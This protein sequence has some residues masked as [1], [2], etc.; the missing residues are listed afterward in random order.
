MPLPGRAVN[1]HEREPEHAHGSEE[2]K[3]PALA[4]ELR[5]EGDHWQVSLVL[6]HNRKPAG[7]TGFRQGV[8]DA[9]DS[10]SE[11]AAGGRVRDPTSPGFTPPVQSGL[12][13]SGGSGCRYGVSACGSIGVTQGCA[14]A[15]RAPD[16]DARIALVGA[17]ADVASGRRL[18]IVPSGRLVLAIETLARTRTG[19]RG[20]LCPQGGA[21]RHGAPQTRTTVRQVG[22]S[23]ARVQARGGPPNDLTRA[24][25]SRGITGAVPDRASSLP[26]SVRTTVKASG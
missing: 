1:R 20:R 25:P 8:E 17:G 24:G 4:A 6:D 16:R 5:P 22:G 13:E 7:Y 3:P 2:Q 9:G 19:A 15:T 26:V 21:W 10:R 12:P 23:D 14:P 18:T 11:I